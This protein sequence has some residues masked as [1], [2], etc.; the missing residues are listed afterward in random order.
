MGPGPPVVALG[1]TKISAAHS[2]CAIL[3]GARACMR[4][5]VCVACRLHRRR[6][7]S[8]MRGASNTR[9]ADAHGGA[10]AVVLHRIGPRVGERLG[11]NPPVE[12][13][14]VGVEHH[15]GMR[16]KEREPRI[17]P[18]RVPRDRDGGRRANHHAE[19]VPLRVR[20][21]AE[22]RAEVDARE[23]RRPHRNARARGG[24]E[25]APGH[26]VEAEHAVGEEGVGD[27]ALVRVRAHDAAPGVA[28][29]GHGGLRVSFEGP[30]DVD[31]AREA[32]GQRRGVALDPNGG[33]LMASR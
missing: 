28:T 32:V 30:P 33:R 15:V 12:G 1:A 3:S 6:C 14:Q 5:L 21:V 13:L 24:R 27:E 7:G 23:A 22:Q 10:G 11:H 9:K 18:V 4:A 26:R 29:E 19:G 16:G 25:R 31:A 8:G 2:M 20:H 17:P